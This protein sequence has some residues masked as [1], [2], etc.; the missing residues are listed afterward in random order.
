MTLPAYTP[1]SSIAAFLELCMQRPGDVDT[2]L[3][4][5]IPTDRMQGGNVPAGVDVGSSAL[6]INRPTGVK[7]RGLPKGTDRLNVRLWGSSTDEV[8]SH[9]RA[10]LRT[11]NRRLNVHLPSGA[12]LYSVFEVSAG[13]HLVEPETG[14]AHLIVGVEV[15]YSEMIVS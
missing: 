13:Q 12:V 5:R 6:T 9:Y 15:Q 1:I 14:W 8:E 4:A 2:P 7:E 11:V 10:F 3:T